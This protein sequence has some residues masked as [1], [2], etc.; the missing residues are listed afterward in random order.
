MAR[1]VGTSGRLKTCG[2]FS[3]LSS[4]AVGCPSAPP[5]F[6]SVASGMFNTPSVILVFFSAAI[7]FTDS[8]SS[9]TACLRHS[10]FSWRHH[11]RGRPI[12]NRGFP[13]YHFPTVHVSHTN[14]S[15]NF[16][17]VFFYF[18]QRFLLGSKFLFLYLSWLFHTIAVHLFALSGVISLLLAKLLFH[19]FVILC[20]RVCTWR[21]GL[22]PFF[23]WKFP[24]VVPGLPA[25]FIWKF[26]P[27]VPGLPA[28]FI[29]KFPP[30]VPGLPASE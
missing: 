19:F 30:V 4:A 25:F 21:S 12:G 14:I 11:F 18:S 1:L 15:P 16:M 13:Q 27:V 2:S 17:T 28:F 7:F 23:I 22:S 8:G 26:P 10:F 29:W 3:T 5:D 24:P 9:L 6:P 20:V